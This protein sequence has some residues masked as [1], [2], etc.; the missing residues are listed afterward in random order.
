MNL[1][2]Y[3][4][5]EDFLDSKKINSICNNPTTSDI[6]N[7]DI[8]NCKIDGVKYLIDDFSLFDKKIKNNYIS[9]FIPHMNL[10]HI[11]EVILQKNMEI[12]INNN[13]LIS[14]PID[15]ND[16]DKYQILI[17]FICING[18]SNLEIRLYDKNKNFSIFGYTL[19]NIF[20]R[21]IKYNNWYNN[22][23]IYFKYLENPKTYKD[24]IED[25][26]KKKQKK[27]C[28]IL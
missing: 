14:F 4:S 28:I 23:N 13:L 16:N 18:L 6:F 8:L 26:N 17:P 24:L 21:I 3:H 2:N 9:Y 25:F 19:Q 12:Y 1:S 7:F 22:Q 27:Y 5:I 10:V 15:L 11:I 20:A